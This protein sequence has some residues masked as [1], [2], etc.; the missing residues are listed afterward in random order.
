VRCT[1]VVFAFFAGILLFR[2]DGAA[3]ATVALSDTSNDTTPAAWLSATLS[4]SLPTPQTLE[5]SVRN[6]TSA[7]APFD[8][9]WIFFNTT[10]E[11]S[12]LDL[13]SATSSTTGDNTSAWRLGDYGYDLATGVF[14]NFDYSL[15]T[16]PGGA[17]SDRIAPG[18]TQS[19]ILSVSCAN[20]G[21]CTNDLLDGW[22]ER[23][24]IP[25][26]VAMRFAYGPG[27][28]AAFGA[29]TTPVPEPSTAALFAL[30][31]AA[32]AGAC[33]PRGIRA[34]RSADRRT[35]PASSRS[36]VATNS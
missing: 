17:G 20:Y 29:L 35:F 8:I 14:G 36:G 33:Q 1:R 19:F 16:E 3:G 13:V 32:L 24:S 15:R 22:S 27:G 7:S 25:A 6:D 2:A 26:R 21:G 34:A 11:V 10:S 9:L 12:Y 4:Y 5:L 18:E 23:G 28:A 31:A 30:G